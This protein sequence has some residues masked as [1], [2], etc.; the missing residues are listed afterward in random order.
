MEVV[1]SLIESSVDPS[2]QIDDSGI[3]ILANHACCRVFDYNEGELIGKNVSILM[4]EEHASKHDGYIE[5]YK[6][7][8]IKKIIGTGRKLRGRKKDGS[9]FPIFLTLSDAQLNGTRVFTGI[10]R[11]MSAEEQERARLRSMINSAVDPIV[12]IDSKGI[13]KEVNPATCKVFGYDEDMLIGRNVNTLMP[14]PH[15]S[16]HDRYLANYLRTGVRKVM[17]TGRRLKGLKSDGTTFPMFLTLS[18]ATIGDQV[19]FT[20]IMRDLSA[21]EQERERMMAMVDSSIDPIVQINSNGIIELVNPACCK[22]FQY[23]AE[24]LIGQNVSILMPHDHG[25]AFFSSGLG[26]T[27][28]TGQKLSARRRDGSFFSV[29]LTLSESKVGTKTYFTGIMRDM[30]AEEQERDRLV[31]LIESAVDPIVQIDSKGNIFMV[32]PACCTTFRYKEEDLLGKNVKV[33][34]P[35]PHSTSHDAYIQ[36][37]LTTG[38]KHV[39]G[40]GRKLRGLRSDGTTFPLLLTLSEATIGED[41]FFTGILRDMSAEEQERERMESMISAAVDPIVQINSSGLIQLVNAA[42]CKAFMY[43][44]KELLGKNVSILMPS[45]HS[46]RHDQYID[47]YM[48]T[49]VKKLLGKGRKMLGRKKNGKLFTIFLTLSEAKVGEEVYFTGILRD[50]NAI[51]FCST[52]Y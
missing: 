43:E 11:D 45:P 31:S 23:V 6:R 18:E 16:N 40:T 30:S 47:S 19:F 2:V 42:C 1:R 37:Y 28:G 5:A 32:N 27:I 12:Q 14:G 3:I 20:G 48:K 24:E 10:M 36:K 25:E 29:F 13:M 41:R 21:E 38:I 4:P 49:G 34:M 33:L 8:G 9:T 50:L 35:D 46:F 39:M 17:G 26:K 7:T 15:A 52:H 22:I 51:H 44:E